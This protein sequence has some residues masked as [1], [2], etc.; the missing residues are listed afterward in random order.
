[1]AVNTFEQGASPEDLSQGDIQT[2]THTWPGGSAQ[3]FQ[4]ASGAENTAGVVILG[5]CRSTPSGAIGRHIFTRSTGPRSQY[6][7]VDVPGVSA[8][9]SERG[10]AFIESGAPANCY[11][12]SA[13]DV[14]EITV[15]YKVL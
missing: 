1:M 2:V 4:L 12:S 13:A 9:Y 6:Y 3:S 11:A 8:L 10:I 14:G 15:W 5:F 7:D